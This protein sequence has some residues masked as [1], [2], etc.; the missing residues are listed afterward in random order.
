MKLK[1]KFTKR[2]EFFIFENESIVFYTLTDINDPIIRNYPYLEMLNKNPSTNYKWSISDFDELGKLINSI[3]S[4]RNNLIN[5][6]LRPKVI[7]LFP[8]D[9]FESERV[10]LRTLFE[11]FAK[12]IYNIE[13]F[14]ICQ[15]SIFSIENLV[16]K[17]IL[18]MG[19]RINQTFSLIENSKTYDSKIFNIN[20]IKFKKWI[21]I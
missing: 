12:E 11:E 21:L 16:G 20:D 6:F 9:I 15:L 14:H 2:T 18:S 1:N 13:F 5:K 8:E 10:F 17:R 3:R 19:D 4:E 7:V